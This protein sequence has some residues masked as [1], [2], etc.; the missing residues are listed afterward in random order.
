MRQKMILAFSVVVLATI[1]SLVLILRNGA[2]NE[3]RMFMN[4]GGMTGS[5]NLVTDLE[6]YYQKNGSFEGAGTLMNSFGAEGMHGQGMGNGRGMSQNLL[7]T[8]AEGIV[9]AD[10]LNQSIGK[11]VPTVEISA[12]IEL[13]DV[14]GQVVGHL[15]VEGGLPINQNAASPLLARLNQAA[16]QA[17]LFAGLIAL[18]IALFFAWRIIAPIRELTRAARTLAAGDLTHRVPVK[19]KDEMAQLGTAFNQMA[20]SLQKSEEAR[21]NM[22]ADIAHELRT[23][24]SVQRAQLE[25]LQDGLYPLTVDNL[26]PV[27]EQTDQLANLVDDLRTLALSDA[28]ELTLDK[29]HLDITSLIHKVIDGF[30][31]V[32]SKKNQVISFIDENPG[33]RSIFADPN[34]LEQVLNNLIGNALRHSPLA[35]KVTLTLSKHQ[36]TLMLKI[37][38]SGV[39]IAEEAMPYIFERFYRADGSRSRHD[40]GSGLGLAIA[41]RIVEMHQGTLT[42]ENSPQGGAVFFVTLPL[43]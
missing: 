31:P 26:H 22:T 33:D 27:L 39:G 42:A 38:D 29:Q 43:A 12:G 19:G 14:T 21:R 4:R 35:G 25:A 1:A 9:L 34:R 17:S 11:T 3:V 23:P 5:E 32:A 24:L 10:K 8:N 18:I 37:M 28:G 16:L 13:H 30:Q 41:R 40:G 6:S 2:A 20:E 7:L 36:E 15:L